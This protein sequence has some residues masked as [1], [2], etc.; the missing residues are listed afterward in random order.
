MRVDP[1]DER[2]ES[3]DTSCTL[4]TRWQQGADQ[5]VSRERS[6]SFILF[7]RKTWQFRWASIIRNYDPSAPRFSMPGMLFHF[8]R[9]KF[10]NRLR[11][12]ERLCRRYAKFACLVSYTV[13]IGN[14]WQRQKM[15]GHFL[16]KRL[17][18]SS[19]PIVAAGKD[20]YRSYQHD[21]RCMESHQHN[22]GVKEVFCSCRRVSHASTSSRTT[23]TA[24]IE[25]LIC[26]EIVPLLILSKAYF[27]LYLV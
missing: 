11:F 2:V 4:S 27:E 23:E 21:W 7:W 5:P 9:E 19:W 15:F 13:N 22:A 17:P 8:S 18:S 24:N 6:V 20:R 10:G 14:D 1:I 12:V 25:S 26:F 3:V 16:W